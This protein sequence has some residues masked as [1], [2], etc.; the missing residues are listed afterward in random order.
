MLNGL[1]CTEEIVLKNGK[2]LIVNPAGPYDVSRI[3]WLYHSVYGGNYPFSLVYNQQETAKAI[4]SDRYL[5]LLA[6]DGKEVVASL[7]LT[8]DRSIHLGKAFGAVVKEELRGL[9]VAEQ[10][11]NFGVDVVVRKLKAARSVYATT[12][13]V[14]LAAQRLTEKTGFKKL[15]VFPNAHKVLKSETHTLAVFYGDDAL[16]LRGT[17]PRLPSILRPFFSIVRRETGLPDAEYVD[18]P[19]EEDETEHSLIPFET[20][21]APQFLQRH[22]QEF[23]TQNKILL[24]FF[25]FS[26]PNL[27]LASPDG[28]TE[29]YIYR[30]TKDGHCVITGAFP[31]NLSTRTMLDHGAAFLESMGVRYLEMLVDAGDAETI[32]QALD[33]RFLPSAYYPAM[34]WDASGSQGRDYLVMSRSLAVLDFKGLALQPAYADYLD[35]YFKL[36]CELNIGKILPPS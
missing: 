27:L 26:E 36:W 4:E 12:R 13:T 9:D 31:G 35:E 21:Q 2:R 34:R 15:G 23:K 28:K 3:R 10:M 5:W 11:L 17:S 19:L 33:A 29:I 22:F 18:F 25:P 14:T 1:D 24:D 8:V 6:R 30:S 16:K 32:S 20:I 7:I